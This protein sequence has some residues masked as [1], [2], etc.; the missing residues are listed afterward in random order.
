MVTMFALASNTRESRASFFAARQGTAAT[1]S[2][3]CWWTRGNAHYVCAGRQSKRGTGYLLC[4]AR[5]CLNA[6][7]RL[8]AYPVAIIPVIA[9]SLVVDRALDCLGRDLLGLRILLDVRT[10]GQCAKK[11]RGVRLLGTKQ[12]NGFVSLAA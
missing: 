1:E 11:H 12:I 8:A 5:A 7:F 4:C 10:W 2:R 6:L 3:L 9:V